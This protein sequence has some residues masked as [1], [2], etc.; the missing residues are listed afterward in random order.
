MTM[1]TKKLI[2]EMPNIIQYWPHSSGAVLFEYKGIE[3][4]F[5]RS[6]YGDYYYHCWMDSSGNKRKLGDQAHLEECKKEIDSILQI[7]FQGNVSGSKRVFLAPIPFY[8]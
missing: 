5:G 1:Y 2:D 6:E 7:G 3:I 8:N 4:C